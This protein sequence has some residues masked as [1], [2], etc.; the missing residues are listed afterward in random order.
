MTCMINGAIA[1][2]FLRETVNIIKCSPFSLLTD[3]SNDTGLEKMNPL[4]VKNFDVNTGRVESRFLDMGATKGTDSATAASIFQKIDDVLSLHGISWSKWVGFGVDN[5]NVN[6]GSRNSIMTRVRQRSPSCYFM[7]CPCHLI[8]MH[9]IACKASE[10][11][12]DT[13]KF[14]LE[15]ICVDTY[16][17]F[18]KSTKRTS[19]LVEFAGFLNVEYRQVIKH[20]NIRWLRPETAVRRNLDMYPKS[21]FLSSTESNPRSKRL[22]QQFADPMVEVYHLLFQ[23]VLPTITFPNKFLQREDPC[24]YAWT[25]E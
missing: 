18:D 16:Y 20:V 3:G 23:A 17:Y 6:L 24:I 21:Y 9:N 11:F 19:V 12:C 10:V 14:S 4:A 7:G 5:T 8:H 22:K 25:V 1:P 13:S 2:H 15:D